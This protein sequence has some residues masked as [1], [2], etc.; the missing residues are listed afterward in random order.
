MGGHSTGL[1]QIGESSTYI[2]RNRANFNHNSIGS[3]NTS[4]M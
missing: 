2:E 4:A 3:N 1:E